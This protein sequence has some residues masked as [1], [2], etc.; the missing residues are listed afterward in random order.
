MFLLRDEIQGKRNFVFLG[1][2]GCG[3]SELSVEFALL[4]NALKERPTHFFDLDM[5]KP[6]FRSREICHELE[7]SGVSVHFEEQFMDAPTLTGGV[8]RLLQDEG[9]YTVLDVGG[10]HIGARAVGG[11]APQLNAAST[12]IYYIIN[13]YRPWST[14][15]VHIDGVLTQALGVSHVRAE[16]LRY[17]ANPNFGLKTTMQDVTEGYTRL[18]KMAAGCVQPAFCCV[19]KELAA[20]I[21]LPVPI[22]PLT[23]RMTYQWEQSIT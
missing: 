23:L 9:C 17:V 10:D 6:L 12:Q 1:E 16:K 22:L 15:L 21:C 19:R 11:Y 13:P 2:A 7:Q 18:Q 4:L 5:S 8:S 14:D 20:D 3:K